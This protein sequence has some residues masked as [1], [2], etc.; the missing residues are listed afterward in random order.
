MKL[1]EQLPHLAI[2]TDE[3]ILKSV[4]SVYFNA[5]MPEL[6]DY[7]NARLPMR[8]VLELKGI[9]IPEGAEQSQIPC[10][11]PSHG[12]EDRHPS[13]RYYYRSRETEQVHE[14]IYCFKCNQVHSAFS[15]ICTLQK[16]LGQRF[17]QTLLFIRNRF[18]IPFPKELFFQLDLDKMFQQQNTQVQVLPQEYYKSITNM[19]QGMREEKDEAKYLSDLQ[20][21]Y[22][23]LTNPEFIAQFTK[24]V[25]S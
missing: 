4:S 16:A 15:L 25:E 14:R 8:K 18:Q 1:I 11:L 24:V 7:Y 20:K 10:P 9:F 12:L 13:C 3:E 21:F 23:L 5:L 22:P 2:S 19:I 6:Y 17:R